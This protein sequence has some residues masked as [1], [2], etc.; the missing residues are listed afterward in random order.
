MA[1]ARSRSEFVRSAIEDAISLYAGFA[2]VDAYEPNQ[3][4]LDLPCAMVGVPFA[5]ETS[6][7]DEGGEH[8]FFQVE[9]PVV[10]VG[11][12]GFKKD[13]PRDAFNQGAY[14]ADRIAWAL[15]EYMANTTEDERT[16]TFDD[17][18]FTFV[19]NNIVITSVSNSPDLQ[20]DT[21]AEVAL[22]IKVQT[23][24]RDL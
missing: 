8:V 18:S 10:I 17:Y 12:Y 6:I 11:V 21:T 9:F 16:I 4:T 3:S 15:S 2:I 13:S 23:H 20:N 24:T 14:M 5:P 19:I 22:Q 1:N 7:E